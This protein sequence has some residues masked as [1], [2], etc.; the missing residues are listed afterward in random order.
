MQNTEF[1]SRT[2]L[3]IPVTAPGTP[4]T[5]LAHRKKAEKQLHGSTDVKNIM[6]FDN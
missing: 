2:G 1:A 6:I 5:E 3:I 4:N